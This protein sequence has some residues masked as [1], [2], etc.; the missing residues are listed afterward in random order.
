MPQCNKCDRLATYDSPEPLCDAHW[1]KW[2]AEDDTPDDPNPLSHKERKKWKKEILQ[3]TRRKY[4][5]QD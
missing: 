3:K 1:A 4:G 2:F 5:R